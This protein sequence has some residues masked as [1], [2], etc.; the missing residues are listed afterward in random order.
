MLASKT[1]GLVSAFITS[2]RTRLHQRQSSSVGD[3]LKFELPFNSDTEA[4]APQLQATLTRARLFYGSGLGFASLPLLTAIVRSTIGARWIPEGGVANALVV[5][6]A[7][8]DQA[9][10]V[11]KPV[12]A[13]ADAAFN[14][15]F[16]ELQRGNAR[17]WAR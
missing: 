15:H 14:S 3:W 16:P 8:L 2:T 17:R 4:L 9:L 12:H 7:D 6:D 10:Q 13:R 1:P 11:R 5:V